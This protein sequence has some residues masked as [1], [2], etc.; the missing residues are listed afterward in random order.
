MDSYGDVLAILPTTSA[1][2]RIS[3]KVL[4]TA[5]PVF[6]SMFS[7]RFRE[8]AALASAT[9]LTEIEFPDD[10]PQA[11]ETIF[12]VLHFRHDCVGEGFD[13]DALYKIA[14]VVD[15]YDLAKALG[16][17]KEVWLRGGAGGGGKRL[18]AMYAF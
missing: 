14:L 8:G 10:S 4:S 12:N 18:F 9:G 17:W 16:P 6:R 7:P 1:K 5:S 13:H 3:S 15:K 2:L 11:L